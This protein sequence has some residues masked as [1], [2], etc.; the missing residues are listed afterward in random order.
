MSIPTNRKVEFESKQFEDS[1][2]VTSKESRHWVVSHIPGWNKKSKLKLLYRA[3]KDGWD[4]RN[5]FHKLCNEKGPTLCLAKSD[6]GKISGGY[7]SVSWSD[8]NDICK[9]DSTAYIFSVDNQ[10]VYPV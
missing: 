7:T 4:S 2:L 3:T 8:D 6:K 9:S 5:N 1:E 10:L